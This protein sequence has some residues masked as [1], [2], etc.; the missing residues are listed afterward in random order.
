[1]PRNRHAFTSALLDPTTRITG[2]PRSYTQL[3]SDCVNK[4]MTIES[5][6]GSFHEDYFRGGPLLYLLVVLGGQR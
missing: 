3:V 5:I 1:M 2:A 4:S 6:L